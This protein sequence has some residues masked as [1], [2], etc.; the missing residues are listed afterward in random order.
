[1]SLLLFK[2]ISQLILPPG[3]LILSAL[4]GAVYYKRIWGRGLLLLS[5]LS[6]WLLATEPVR[7]MLLNP[8][9]QAHGSLQLDQLSTQEKYAIVLLGGGIYEKAPEYGGLDSLSHFAMMRTIYAAD[10]ALKTGFD[11]YPSGGAVFSDAT[12]S[13]AKVMQRWLIQFGVAEASIHLD[14]EARNTWENAVNTK[15]LLDAKGISSIILVTTAWHMPRSVWSFEAQGL[16]VIAAPCDYKVKREPYGLRSYLPHWS[17]F[18]DSCDALHEY[19]GMIWYR[20]KQL[21]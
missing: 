13:E 11:V 18:A 5:L 14:T 21:W 17:V 8:L 12:E 3:G 16:H 9:E 6:F 7:D 10:L 1:M 2:S 4:L 19:L 15:A 20:L